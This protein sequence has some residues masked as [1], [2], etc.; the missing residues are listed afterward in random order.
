MLLFQDLI[1]LWLLC[2]NLQ[3]FT[4]S[5]MIIKSNNCFFISS[6][7][8]R[9]FFPIYQVFHIYEQKFN[10]CGTRSKTK[11]FIQANPFCKLRSKKLPHFVSLEA[12][13]YLICSH[14]FFFTFFFKA[15]SINSFV[16]WNALLT[17][18]KTAKAIFNRFCP[19]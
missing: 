3:I 15:L 1:F 18:S 2:L 12:K 10:Q 13:N 5:S 17:A 8:R 16:L 4:T 6:F 19:F 11:I 7:D 14:L 9:F